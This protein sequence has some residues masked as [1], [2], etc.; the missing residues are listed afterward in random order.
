MTAPEKKVKQNVVS[1]LVELG[2]Y[3]F[4]PATGGYGRSGIPD[5]VACLDGQFIGIECKAGSNKMTPLQ[6]REL[7]AIEDSGGIAIIY[8]E[9]AMSKQ[10][11]RKL[12]RRGEGTGKD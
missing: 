11:L 12:L 3:Y 7:Q 5:V 10:D 4:Y 1:V 8:S 9:P 6:K 2:A